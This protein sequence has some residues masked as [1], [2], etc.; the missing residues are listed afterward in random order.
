MCLFF[1]TLGQVVAELYFR[2]IR[3]LK[4][5][6]VFQVLKMYLAESGLTEGNILVSNETR[7]GIGGANDI[8]SSYNGI[9]FVPFRGK[10]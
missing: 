2:G 9:V 10:H 8:T 7:Q 3:K 6:Y 1:E 4:K 5:I